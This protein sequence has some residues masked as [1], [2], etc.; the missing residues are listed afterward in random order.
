MFSLHFS[1]SNVEP[2]LFSLHFS[3]PDV[4]NSSR[5]FR[6]LVDFPKLSFPTLFKEISSNSRDFQQGKIDEVMILKTQFSS[7][8]AL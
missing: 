5:N 2:G 6:I 1:G 8:P 4:N 7:L 3:G